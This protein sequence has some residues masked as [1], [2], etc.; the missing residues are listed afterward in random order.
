VNRET[1]I[2]LDVI[3]PIA[4][5]VVLLSHLSF[6]N[7]SGQMTSLS[8]SGVQAV[9][10]FFVLSGFVIASVCEGRERD[11][12]SYFA[13]R[14]LR[15]YSVALPAIAATVCLDCVGIRADPEVYVG[16]FQP[17]GPGLLLRSVS[18]TGEQW[19]AHRFPGSNGPYWSLGFEVWYYIAFGAMMFAPARWKIGLVSLVLLFIGPKVAILFPLWLMGVGLYKYC[20]SLPKVKNRALG[21]SLYLL[22]MIAIAVYQYVPQ[23]QT[24]P[25]MNIT[26]DGYL[27]CVAQNYFIGAVFCAHIIGFVI[28]SNAFSRVLGSIEPAVRWVAGATFSIYL[29]HL[30]ILYFLTAA[31]PMPKH[32]AAS[33]A[34]LIALTVLACFV[35]AELFER[36]NR[37]WMRFVR[38]MMGLSPQAG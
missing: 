1:S 18:F 16:P 22:S 29:V 7:L 8:G 21:W 12:R 14:A 28:I 10:V 35:F 6:P 15:I 37:S 32:Q 25:F 24:Q 4:A 11:A 3:R 20:T 5:F 13:S 23:P 19:W 33:T 36:R 31:L 2:Y 26:Y 27:W 38:G 34:A 9:S 17:V 30:P